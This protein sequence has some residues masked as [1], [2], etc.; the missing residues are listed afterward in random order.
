VRSNRHGEVVHDAA[1]LYQQ[2]LTS[3]SSSLVVQKLSLNA[4]IEIK[5]RRNNNPKIDKLTEKERKGKRY[6]NIVLWD[7]VL[8]RTIAVKSYSVQ[9]TA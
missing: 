4:A 3:K 7:K 6:K 8:K 5:G 9:E 2:D 1:G